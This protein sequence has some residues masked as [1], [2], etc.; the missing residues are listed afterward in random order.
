MRFIRFLFE[1]SWQ[2]ILMATIAGFIGGAGNALLISLINRSVN[3]AAFPNAVFYF[4]ALTVGI[5]I[6]STLSQFLL[7][8]LSQNAVYQLRVR[9]SRSILSSPLTHLESLGENRL[10][11]TLT[12]DARVLS[13]TL[14]AIPNLCIDLATVLGALI[15]L[16]YLSGLIF[17]LTVVSSSLAMWCVQTRLGKA[18]GLF[19]SA[20]A[21]EDTLVKHFQ[22]ITKGIKELKLHKSRR[23]DFSTNHLQSSAAKLRHKNSTA[24]KSFVV[25]NAFGQTTQFLSL[26]FILFILPQIVGLPRELLASYILTTTFLAMPLHNLLSKLPDIMRGNVALQK[27]DAMKLSLA[28]RTEVETAS[29]HAVAQRC[30]LELDHVTY[31]Y[32]PGDMPPEGMPPGGEG[33]LPF[34][35]PPKRANGK[36]EPNHPEHPAEG[37]FPIGEPPEH[38][39]LDQNGRPHP[40]FQPENGQP[41]HAEGR[42]NRE[43]GRPNT[44]HPPVGMHPPNGMHPPGMHPPDGRERGFLLGPISMTLQ[45][46]QITF[47]VGGNGSGKSTLAKL[48]TGLYLPQTGSVRLDGVEINDQNQEWY[49]QHFTA[50]FSDFYLFESYLGFHQ[51]NL[52]QEVQNYLRQLQLDHKV[53]VK[54]GVLSTIHLSQGQRKRLALLTAYLEDRPIYLFDE[55]AADQ[56]PM[57]RDLF[58]TQIL[59]KLKERGKAVLVITHDDRYFHLA[60]QLI[61]LDYGRVVSHPDQLPLAGQVGARS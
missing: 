13:H 53:Q 54:D 46:G 61:K 39:R 17:A 45:P 32:H 12:D 27:I 49:R 6:T 60:D 30:L 43:N 21:E 47:V 41:V 58:Y 19:T 26:G 35:P 10:I 42:P 1:V 55:W 7:I 24:M 2:N 15:Y 31:M 50:I 25:A 20:R 52:D 11:A 22:A 40:E 29:N 59:T 23:D 16:A 44:M 34:G 36:Q 5:L 14:A 28:E 48:I 57:F 18:Q 9:L 4:A 56:E 3:Q 38:G 37:N 51:D 8:R 33:M